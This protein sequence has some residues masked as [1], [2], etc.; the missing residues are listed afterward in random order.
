MAWRAGT[1][2]LP[3]VQCVRVRRDGP[4]S[5][6]GVELLSISRADRPRVELSR[7]RH[8]NLPPH[9][10]VEIARDEA[11][12]TTPP[13]RVRARSCW[14]PPAAHAADKPDRASAL[15]GRSRGPLPARRRL[16]VP[17]R[18]RRPGRQAALHAQ[19]S[20]ERLEQG[21]GAERVEPRRP[22]ERVDGG[23][24]RL[25]PQGLRA[26]QRRLRAG[27]GVPLR[28]G[29]LPRARCGSTARRWARTPAPTSRSRSVAKALKRKGTN[30]LVV[31][32][33]SRRKVTDFPPAGLNTDGVPTG[34]WWN[35]SGIQREVYL[36]EARHG[37][38]PEGP[39]PA[40]DRLRRP[41]RR[42]VKVEDQPQERHPPR[43]A[44]HDHR[45]VRRPTSSTSGTKTIGRDG[46]VGVRRHAAHRQA[47][48]VVAGRPAPLRRQ[49]HRPRRR[50]E[51]R[52]LLAAQRDPLDQGL[53]RAP[54]P[55]RPAT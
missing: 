2:G 9:A 40:G 53:Q 50:Q 25:V 32:V 51:G 49:L 10:R 14:S 42:S 24:D 38:L 52:G 6:A 43:P 12:P 54:G 8:R 30:R 39:G 4:L 47:A 48:A 18:Q 19:T 36:R 16:A 23:R 31:R 22:V 41:A 7:A 46:I 28:V 55:Q 17:A 26:A 27:L 5:G 29:Q 11:P 21:H 20:H 44:R 1:N 33:D 15:P 34:G 13:A 37:R 45:Q 35:Y 3:V